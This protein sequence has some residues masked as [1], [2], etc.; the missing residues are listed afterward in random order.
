MTPAAVATAYARTCYTDAR[1]QRCLALRASG[2]WAVLL[3]VTDN[4]GRPFRWMVV[5][6][7]DTV[8][9][10]Q[11]KAEWCRLARLYGR[12]LPEWAVRRAVVGRA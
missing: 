1:V 3:Q 12:T 11:S 9:E 10:E 4:C 2:C 6:E 8:A 5:V 7:G